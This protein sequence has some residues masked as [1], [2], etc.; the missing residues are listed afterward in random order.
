MAFTVLYFYSRHVQYSTVPCNFQHRPTVKT[1]LRCDTH[2]FERSSMFFWARKECKNLSLRW[3]WQHSARCA[4][5]NVRV[6]LAVESVSS[7]HYCTGIQPK[8][9]MRSGIHWYSTWYTGPRT[10]VH[11]RWYVYEQAPHKPHTSD[12][13]CI[14]C[15]GIAKTGNLLVRALTARIKW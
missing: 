14:T 4:T 6:A 5:L 3:S 9:S 7:D 1:H 12:G 10:M 11:E 8:S 15:Y 2:T 13:L